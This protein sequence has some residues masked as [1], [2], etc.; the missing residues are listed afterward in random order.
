MVLSRFKSI[1]GTE[2][3]TKTYKDSE[4]I[5]KKAFSSIDMY[6]FNLINTNFDFHAAA[7]MM[8][9]LI[10]LVLT[11]GY[12]TG[13]GKTA[14]CATIA[15]CGTIVECGRIAGCGTIM[16]VVG[17]TKC[18]AIGTG[19]KFVVATFVEITRS[20]W[21]SSNVFGNWN[22]LSFATR[23]MLHFGLGISVPIQSNC[24]GPGCLFNSC[25]NNPL[26]Y[27]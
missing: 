15:G 3:T 7:G 18:E 10:I 11:C 6:L 2:W 8:T 23:S 14:G 19:N 4:K 16:D 13:C 26:K 5:Y 21:W 1:Q 20:W 27:S 22:P 24:R 25:T 9:L 12:T 17:P